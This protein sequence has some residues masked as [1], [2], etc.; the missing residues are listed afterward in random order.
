[1]LWW[2]ILVVKELFLGYGNYKLD[3]FKFENGEVLKNVNVEYNITGTPKYDDDGNMVNAIVYCHNFNGSCSSINDL[4]QITADGAPLDKNKY[5][6][7]SITTLGF[8]DSC[9]PSSTG[10]KYNFPK[11]TVRDMVNFNRKFLNEFLNI[12]HVLGICGTGLGGYS[13]YTWACEYPDEMD[14]IMVCDSSYKT[15]GYRYVITKAV[16]SIIE[17]SEGYYDDTYNES[18]S[19][20]MVAVYRLLYSFYFSKKVFHEMSNDEI[21]VLMEDYVNEGLFTDI[22]DIKQVNDV[23]LN[24]NVEDKLGEIKAKSLIFGNEDDLYYSVIHDTLPLNDLIKNSTVL[25]YKSLKNHTGQEDYS[26]MF[27]GFREFL[28][29]FEK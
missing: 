23:I 21:D 12:T 4:Y 8:S 6:F 20:T 3:E 13:V 29:E 9:S 28:K 19:K 5:C 11:Y 27:D 1:M 7:I 2:F 16:D 17:S 15:N 22:Y 24:F 10:L 14:F 26:V 18:L 25:L